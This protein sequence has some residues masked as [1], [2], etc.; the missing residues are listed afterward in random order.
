M[1]NIGTVMRKDLVEV[2][3]DRYSYSGIVIQTVILLSITGVVVP[4]LDSSIW[5]V[6]G[7]L[8]LFTMFPATLA[9]SQAADAFAGERERGTLD[10]L[11]STPL[12][13]SDIFVGK[14]G[15]AVCIGVVMS[16]VS[17]LSAVVVALAFGRLS[18]FPSPLL[19]VG[20]ILGATVTSM[21][22]AGVGALVSRSV[23][24]ARSAQQISF[25]ISIVFVGLSINMLSGLAGMTWLAVIGLGIA[26]LPCGIGV[27]M[28]LSGTFSRSR[29]FDAR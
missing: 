25:M 3:G 11:M 26:G 15:A 10:T 22:T 8:S 28:A 9:A 21:V 1:R 23:P 24:V 7:S 19:F 14:V 18:V 5:T 16:I 20:V 12:E 6:S 2:A 13:D 29:V 27:L 4:A 17:M